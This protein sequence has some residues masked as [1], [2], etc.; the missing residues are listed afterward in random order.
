M[1]PCSPPPGKAGFTPTLSDW[2]LLSFEHEHCSRHLPGL[3]GTEGFVHICQSSTTTDHIVEVELPLS[4]QFEIP[5]HVELKAIGAHKTPLD[6]FL[7]K[8]MR[9]I[10]FKLLSRRHHPHDHRQ[11]TRS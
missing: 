11:A 3:H 1:L 6:S 4:I 2:I 9:G 8:E 10:E 7:D 5:G